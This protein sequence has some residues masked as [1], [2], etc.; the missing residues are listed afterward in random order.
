MY[1][2]LCVGRG[3]LTVKAC[4]PRTRGVLGRVRGVKVSLS[5]MQ[6]PIRHSSQISEF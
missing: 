5:A 3:A 4:G 2:L 6:T 1:T